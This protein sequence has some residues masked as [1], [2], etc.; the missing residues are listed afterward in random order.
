MRKN[1]FMIGIYIICLSV[2]S[3]YTVSS[4]ATP[5]DDIIPNN[6]LTA[7]NS[8]E[9]TVADRNIKVNTAWAVVDQSSAKWATMTEENRRKKRLPTF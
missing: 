6:A 5:T 4:F 8:T 9:N 1:I 7:L 2:V 3:F